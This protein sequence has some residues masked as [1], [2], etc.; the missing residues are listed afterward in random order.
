M[1]RI[2]FSDLHYDIVR[3]ICEI[4][5][6]E[7][8]DAIKNLSRTSKH[9]RNITLP[10][11]SDNISV[12]GEYLAAEQCLN[13]LQ[14]NIEALRYVQSACMLYVSLGMVLTSE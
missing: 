12:K 10:D 8:R 4:T 1:P 2:S 6:S 14:N 11:I 5:T 13:F 7:S 3:Q 9:F